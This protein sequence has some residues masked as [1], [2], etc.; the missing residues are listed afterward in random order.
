ML[1]RALVLLPFSPPNRIEDTKMETISIRPGLVPYTLSAA[2]VMTVGSTL[3]KQGWLVAALICWAVLAPIVVAAVFDRI[4]RWR[5]GDD[6]WLGS[7]WFAAATASNLLVGRLTFV[8]GV[9]VG[10]GAVLPAQHHD[11][12]D[13]RKLCYR[14]CANQLSHSHRWSRR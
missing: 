5:W 13:A 7:V 1:P 4:V 2:V 6:A 9:A 10:L 8:T 3:L 14:R 11:R 12:D